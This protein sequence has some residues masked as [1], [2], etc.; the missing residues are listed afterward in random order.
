MPFVDLKLEYRSIKQE[1]DAAIA[2][3]I[4][5]CN[6]IGG[7]EISLFEKDF[8]GYIGAKHCVA[9]GNGTDAL[10][11]VL[12]AL[13]VKRGDEIIT[14]ANTF[15]ATSEAITLT[16]A[17][18]TFVDCDPITYN[19]DVQK[20]RR[21]ITEK[22]KGMIV[23]HLYG[24]PASMKELK[25]VAANFGLFV[26]EDAAQAHGAS[27][28]GTKVG[29]F[30]DAACFSFYPGK[31]LGA[32]GDAGAIVTNDEALAAKCRKYANHGRKSKYVHDVEGLNSRLDSIQ[33]AVLNVKLRYLDKWNERRRRSAN[34]YRELLQGAE[35]ELPIECDGC[36]HVYHLF[37]VR[38]DQREN[39]QTYLKENSIETGVHYPVALPN[40]PAYNYLGLRPEDY[41]V[42]TKYSNRVLSLPLYPGITSSQIEYV[43][44]KLTIALRRFGQ[45]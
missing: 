41:P 44:E 31:N 20:V 2:D 12:K 42:A 36:N 16:G 23:V 9:V 43:C 10:F 1:I 15:I 7:H 38:L 3:V 5:T 14:V 24:Q 39:I 37:V 40:L 8:A 27:I 11:I 33:A 35:L 28:N 45:R 6:F 32:Y 19:I 13:G 22:T 21:A 26:V 29:C 17:R 34:L 25:E 30:G 18:V 4:D